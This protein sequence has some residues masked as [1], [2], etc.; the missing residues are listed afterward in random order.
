MTVGSVYNQRTGDVFI[1]DFDRGVVTT[2]GAVVNAAETM[3]VI[4]DMPGVSAPPDFEGIPVYFAFPDDTIDEKILPSIIVRRDAITPAMSRWHLG[5]LQYNVPAI[6]A[7]PVTIKSPY[8]GETIAEGF[9]AYER[10]DQAVPY[11][12]LYTIEI[13]ARFRNNLNVE[14]LR[15]LKY[16]MTKY[17][18]YTTLALKDSLGDTRFYDAFM[19]T[20][21]AADIAPDIAGREANFNVTLRVEGELD[22]NNP[23]NQKVVTNLIT[24]VKLNKP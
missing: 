10:K 19:E 12:L 23:S 6:G 22:L 3:Y 2:L 17:Q 9:D 24:I 7:N 1:Y 4:K 16:V 18:P 13:R 5:A 8:T 15:M 21:S 14:S 20:P 11:D